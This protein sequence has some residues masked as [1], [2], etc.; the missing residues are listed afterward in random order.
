MHK[1]INDI[2]NKE[3]LSE[4]REEYIIVPNYKKGDKTDYRGI[5]LLSAVHKVCCHV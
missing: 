1:I 5:S 4:Q 2:W 3:E